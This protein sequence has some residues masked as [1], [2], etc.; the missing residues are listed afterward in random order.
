MLNVGL[1]I[2]TVADVLTNGA[3]VCGGESWVALALEL[4]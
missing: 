4:F 2:K 3:V 1:L